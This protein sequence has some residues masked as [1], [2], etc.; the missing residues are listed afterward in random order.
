MHRLFLLLTLLFAQVT[1]AAPQQ[2]G[3]EGKTLLLPVAPRE[4][5]ERTIQQQKRSLL[6]GEDYVQ[7]LTKAQENGRPV[8]LAFMGTGWCPWTEKLDKEILSD[9][10]FM[11][12]LKEK[13]NFVWLNCPSNK[14]N[15]SVQVQEL[16]ALYGIEE[17]PTIVMI[18]PMQ[19]EMFRIGYL[20]LSPQEYAAQIEKMMKDYNELNGTVD[21]QYQE[22]SS[23]S[24]EQIQTLY[25]KACDLKSTRYREAL[26][27]LGLEKDAGTF[28]L[29]EKYTQLLESGNKD[30]AE[31]YREK[32]LERD[33]KNLK[34]SQL[35]LA[36][37][38]FQIKSHHLKKKSS[39]SVLKPLVEYLAKFGEKDKENAWRVEMM[40]AQYL[41]TKN[42]ITEALKHASAACLSAPDVHK[43]EIAQTVDYLKTY[44]SD[45]K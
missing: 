45:S 10:P 3:S 27:S 40:A 36:I 41:F 12:A 4:Q 22:L 9:S 14:G 19:E 8:L 23:L 30:E 26:M 37:L 28:F 7:T 21:G 5:I 20:P 38:D 25:Q 15:T 6:W 17:L 42:E 24:L 1:Y 32:I 35:R 34:G 29:L 31:S 13:V 16:K 44:T 11:N 2:M 39:K 33:P 18:T 43:P